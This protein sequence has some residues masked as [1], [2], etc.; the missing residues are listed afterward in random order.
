MF[1]SPNVPGSID[2][3]IDLFGRVR[4]VDG[5]EGGLVKPSKTAV[6]VLTDGVK[7]V[8]ILLKKLSFELNSG[9]GLS[10]LNPVVFWIGFG[11]VTNHPPSSLYSTINTSSDSTSSSKSVLSL[12]STTF[13]SRFESRLDGNSSSVDSSRVVL[14]L[15]IRYGPGHPASFGTVSASSEHKLLVDAPAEMVNH[16]C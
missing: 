1:P 2:L 5:L 10:N 9:R 12:P 3:A 16:A 15:Q 7:L 8:D 14:T 6:V 13:A 4:A 11:V